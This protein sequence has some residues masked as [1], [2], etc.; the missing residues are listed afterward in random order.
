[1][2][3]PK[4]AE[5]Q[6][7]SLAQLL[8]FCAP[9]LP[10]A[11]L[12]LPLIAFLPEY[13]ASGIGLGAAAFAVFSIVRLF[14]I[15]VDPPLG[16]WMDRTRTKIGRFK[17]W[18]LLC[19]PVLVISTWFIFSASKGVSEAYLGLWLF[20]LY[21]G[22]SMAALSQSGWGGSLTTNYNER[23]KIF[24]FWQV[25]N[26][27]GIVLV[28]LIPVYVQDILH[29]SYSDAIRYIGYFIMGSLPLMIGL[30]LWIV[31]EKVS[32]A[33]THDIKFSHYFDML[34]RKNVQRVLWADLFLGLAPGVMSVLFYYFFEQVKGL[35]RPESSKAIAVYFISG[36]LGAPI[37]IWAAKRF[38][39]HITLNISS[40]IF[41]V[42]YA[43]MAILPKDNS[44]FAYV[45]C[46]C[47]GIPYAASLLLTRSLMADIGDEVMSESGHDH[48]GTLM[49]IL[50]ATTKI[51]YAISA[52][53]MVVLS[54]AFGFN[55]KLA[56]NSEQSLLWLQIF[57][58]GL[59]IVF[60]L[61]GVFSMRGY[62]LTPERHQAIQDTLKARGL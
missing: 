22:F 50:S 27:I 11:A 19:L 30:A 40:I 24:A 3:Q 37:W 62:D 12:G 43:A 4:Q 20:V 36:I 49:A 7:V 54:A 33:Q 57:F 34:K 41:A 15:L 35:D 46:A 47:A 38:T 8:A 42:A 17:L 28:S 53:C 48:K 14:D 29:Q 45:L 26:I 2:N 56:Q 59:P 6:Q 23:T 10:F 1:M 25:G 5:P 58:V 21:V 18:I 9:C 39:K 51:G 52:L 44:V 60:L 31:P 61:S 13:Y 16:Y 55:S 32:K